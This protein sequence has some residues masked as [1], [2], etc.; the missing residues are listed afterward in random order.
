M[1]EYIDPAKKAAKEALVWV[2]RQKLLQMSEVSLVIDSYDD[3]FSD[4]D[5]RVFEKRAMSDDFIMEMKRATRGT[6][7]GVIELTFLLP[8]EQRKTE[9]EAKIKKRLKEYF[10]KHYEFLSSEVSLIQRKALAM[11]A[12]G[13]LLSV[14][15]AVFIYPNESTNIVMN[16]VLVLI[17]PAAWFTIW[18]GANKFFEAS[19]E[20][21]PDLEFYKK[22]MKSEINFMGY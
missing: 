15:A 4:F 8:V 13:I 1:P 12:V 6:T 14:I 18:E 22:M 17:E 7:V 21:K 3:I 19:K 20:K 11:I 2:E 5:P 9:T 16:L 10:K